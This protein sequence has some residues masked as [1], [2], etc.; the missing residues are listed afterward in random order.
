MPD[1]IM[2]ERAAAA[3]AE[4]HRAAGW[5]QVTLQGWGRSSSAA[6]LAAR[7]ERMRELM[8]TLAVPQGRTLLPDGGSLRVSDEEE[9]ALFRATIGGMGL[10]GII[11]AICFR[12]QPVPSNA[13]SVQ[14]RRM[15]NLDEFLAGFAAAAETTWSVGWIDALATG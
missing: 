2:D 9:P 11:T 10:T 4:A 8:D 14:S 1:T 15:R 7:P 12:M 3:A 13:L 6:C 5:K